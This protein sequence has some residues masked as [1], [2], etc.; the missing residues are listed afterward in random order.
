MICVAPFLGKN[1]FPIFLK[2]GSFTAK[3]TRLLFSRVQFDARFGGDRLFISRTAGD[4]EK[5]N[6]RSKRPKKF[7][8][9]A[10]SCWEMLRRRVSRGASSGN[11]RLPR[12]GFL[13]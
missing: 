11:V 4:P 13:P 3:P 10:L 1:I 5:E 8:L 7:Q 12:C 2:G 6:A 9:G